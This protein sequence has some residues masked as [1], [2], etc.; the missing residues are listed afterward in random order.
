M[1]VWFCIYVLRNRRPDKSTR[2]YT[3]LH[4]R[5]IYRAGVGNGKGWGAGSNGGEAGVSFVPLDQDIRL[6]GANESA[7]KLGGEIPADLFEAVARVLAF[8]SRLGNRNTLGG[9]L[10]L[11]HPVR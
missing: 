7:V 8:L 4:T 9:I 6:A 11:P 10:R 3:L 2:T 1:N 5:T